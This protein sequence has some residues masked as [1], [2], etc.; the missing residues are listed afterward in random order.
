[1]LGAHGETNFPFIGNL[2]LLQQE[3]PVIMNSE[4]MN[5]KFVQSNKATHDCVTGIFCTKNSDMNSHKITAKKSV[6]FLI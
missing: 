1:M 6:P 2:G 3:L 5:A 4:L